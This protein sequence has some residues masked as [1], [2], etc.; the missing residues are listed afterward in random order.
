L[1]LWDSLPNILNLTKLVEYI[2]SSYH[3]FFFVLTIF[4]CLCR[5]TCLKDWSKVK[6]S[7]KS[8]Y[9]SLFFHVDI[10]LLWNLFG[11]GK[12]NLVLG[13]LS[14]WFSLKEFRFD[15]WTVLGVTYNAQ[16]CV[17]N[18]WYLWDSGML[19]KFTFW[20]LKIGNCGNGTNNHKRIPEFVWLDGKNRP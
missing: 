4:F 3:R 12:I 2:S 9:I 7:S 20:G 11:V 13:K 18:E 15:S 6:I 5:K 14:T 10:S 16:L 19:S 8:L 1:T 17:I